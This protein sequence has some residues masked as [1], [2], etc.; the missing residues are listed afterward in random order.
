MTSGTTFSCATSEHL[1]ASAGNQQRFAVWLYPAQAASGARG[2]GQERS[3]VSDLNLICIPPAGL[4]LRRQAERRGR[5]IPG[6]SPPTGEG[7]SGDA[8]LSKPPAVAASGSF[9]RR[10]RQMTTSAPDS[11]ARTDRPDCQSACPDSSG[12]EQGGVGRSV[13]TRATARVAAGPEGP[14]G[15]A[16]FL[17]AIV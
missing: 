4:E 17:Y 15:Q 12:Q 3:A 16:P 1:P 13:H 14:R 2:D 8:M 5:P 9:R 11:L 6:C 10:Q 7:K